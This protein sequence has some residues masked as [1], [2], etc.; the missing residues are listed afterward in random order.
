MIIRRKRMAGGALE[1]ASQEVR[2][3]LDSET[4]DPT[5]VAEYTMKDTN[6]LVEEFMLLANTSVAE[7]ILKVTLITIIYILHLLLLLVVVYSAF[8]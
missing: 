1:L 5:D 2:F 8:P 7:Q 3:E 6:R 4:S